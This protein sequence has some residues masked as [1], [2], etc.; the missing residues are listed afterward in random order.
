MRV[1]EC[2]S[3]SYSLLLAWGISGA[4]LLVIG[5]RQEK[6]DKDG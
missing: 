3:H 2:P 6:A 4:W 5:V 1:F